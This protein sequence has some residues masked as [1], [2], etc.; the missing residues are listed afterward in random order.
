MEIN[1]QG[2]DALSV[3]AKGGPFSSEKP[4]PAMYNG[5]TILSYEVRSMNVVMPIN[6]PRHQRDT[7]HVFVAT[8][9]TLLSAAGQARICARGVQRRGRP[10]SG[11]RDHIRV[12]KRSFAKRSFAKRS[13]AKRSF[14]KWTGI[15]S[16][17]F[18]SK[19]DLY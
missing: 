16:T 4:I 3:A 7:K 6:Q 10:D 17:E 11:D 5:Q 13:F 15:A 19:R 18:G 14:A 9:L 8:I 1:R 12:P 2:R